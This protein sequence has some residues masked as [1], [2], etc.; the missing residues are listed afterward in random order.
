MKYGDRF[1]ELWL[2]ATIDEFEEFKPILP[3]KPA[4]SAKAKYRYSYKDNQWH[5]V[6]RFY[7]QPIATMLKW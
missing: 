1:M 6:Y 7:R 3:L 4:V 2:N 5:Q